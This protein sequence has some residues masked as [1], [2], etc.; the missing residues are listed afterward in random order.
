MFNLS[1]RVAQHP[2]NDGPYLRHL[3]GAV[4][5]DEVV[6]AREL[7]FREQ[8]RAA[9]ARVAEDAARKRYYAAIAKAR[10][11]ESTL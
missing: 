6:A 1:A 7:F 8:E 5:F 2:I 3:D 10:L 9:R 4:I 11:W